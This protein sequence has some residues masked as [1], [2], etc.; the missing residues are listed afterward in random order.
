[1]V[2]I[3]KHDWKLFRERVPQWQERYME[4]LTKEYIDLLS[5]PGNASDH[6]WELEKRIKQDKKNPG[7]L[8]EMR[9]STAIWDIA[10]YVGNKV[11]TLDE[12]EGFSEDL[13]DAVKLILSR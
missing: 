1:M 7:V 12:L 4:R 2:E 9:R 8:I 13:I 10:I 3:S 5:S 6:F 11:I